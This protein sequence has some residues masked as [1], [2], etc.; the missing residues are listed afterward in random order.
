MIRDLRRKAEAAPIPV[1]EWVPD[2]LEQGLGLTAREAEVLMWVAQG[3]TNPEVGGILGIRP[4][5]VRTHL[6]RIF[7]KLGV[8][9]RHAAGLKAIQVLG[10]P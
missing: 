2:P 7:A 10:L 9:T 8:E 6:E 4:Y 3:K 1:R 5:T